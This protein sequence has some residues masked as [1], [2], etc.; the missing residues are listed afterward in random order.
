MATKRKY[1]KRRGSRKIRGG[2]IFG[3]SMR[4]AKAQRMKKAAAATKHRRK[5]A[6]ADKAILDKARANKKAKSARLA[7]SLQVA[8]EGQPGNLTVHVMTE[9]QESVE[10]GEEDEGEEE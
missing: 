4:V 3:H 8:A 6:R 9:E 7:S 2:T 10:E 5:N 1:S